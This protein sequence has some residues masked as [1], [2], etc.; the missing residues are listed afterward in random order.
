MTEP[1]ILEYFSEITFEDI[2]ACL[3]FA[4]DSEKSLL[5]AWL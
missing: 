2:K 1:Q 4:A 3:T 5:V